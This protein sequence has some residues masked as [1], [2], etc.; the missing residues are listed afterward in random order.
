MSTQVVTISAEATPNPNTVK[1]NVGRVLL[2][3]GVLNYTSPERARESLLA[4]RLFENDAIAGVMIGRDFIS[5]TKK[6]EAQWADVAPE[7]DTIR[8]LLES[9]E[10]LFPERPA[11]RDETASEIERRIREVLDRDIRPAVAMDG[12]DIEFYSFDDG[13]VTLHLQGACGSCPSSA[14]TLKMGVENRL[15]QLIPEV[16]E[17]VQI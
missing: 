5:L 1:L 11:E 6:P 7:V 12:G 4:L 17:V 8:K 13:V 2:E 9:G 15:R 3:R 10:T 14:L 16:K